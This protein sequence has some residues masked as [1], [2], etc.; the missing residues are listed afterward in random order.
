[1]FVGYELLFSIAVAVVVVDTA[2]GGL[3]KIALAHRRKKEETFRAEFATQGSW[4]DAASN[5]THSSLSFVGSDGG[6]LM[7]MW[8]V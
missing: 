6:R 7:R 3:S 4:E 5:D 8:D 1:M 2:A